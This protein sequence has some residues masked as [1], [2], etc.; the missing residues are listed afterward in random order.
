[1]KKILSLLVS[2]PL[3]LSAVSCGN[4]SGKVLLPN[5]SGKAGE[6]VV[7]MDKDNWEGALGTQ[8]RELL[9]QDCPFLP[10]RE[11]MYNL[12]SLTPGAFGDLF[13]VHRN[14]VFFNLD[15][16]VASNG[17]VYRSD[18]WAHPQCLVQI[19]ACCADSA[20]VLLE[21]EGEVILGALEQAERNRVIVNTLLYEEKSIAPQVA[22]VLGG[23]VHCPSGYKL[24]KKTDDFVWIAYEKQFSTQGLLL[25]KYPVGDATEP[26]TAEKIIAHRNEILRENVPG[27][28]ENTW[29]TTSTF[30][31]PEVKFL[32]YKGRDFAETRGLW[33]VQNDY[34]GGP[35]VSHSFYSRDGKDIIV[36][37]AFVYAPKYDK[38]HYLR[39]VE[40]LLYSFEWQEE[41]EGKKE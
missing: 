2:A 27:M 23:A 15:P 25:Y 31:T 40:S 29:M 17:V 16:A 21:R 32:R 39:Q 12:V 13:K 8:A 10:Q 3:L 11:P 9:A 37:E 20:S 18:V 24:L 30:L 19:N 5:V 28:F 41:E 36:L 6:V 1:M 7:V 34:M 4:S 38:R 35:F 22:E 33:E 26:F 14:I